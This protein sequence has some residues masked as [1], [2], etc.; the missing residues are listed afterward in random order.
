M[1]AR[2]RQTDRATDRHLC[3]CL[4]IP[5][6]SNTIR[7]V[8]S[9]CKQAAQSR[10][11]PSLSLAEIGGNYSLRCGVEA[12]R[13]EEP[14]YRQGHVGRGKA[15]RQ[16]KIVPR[17]QTGSKC[18]KD[19]GHSSWSCE[20]E[21]GCSTA[22]LSDTFAF[23]RLLNMA[24]DSFS[25]AA[26]PQ[27]AATCLVCDGYLLSH[28]AARADEKGSRRLVPSTPLSASPHTTGARQRDHH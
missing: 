18:V 12:L 26:F 23:T 28:G 1:R 6:Q 27:W 13:E 15:W 14:P 7:T 21:P 2:H 11:R 24:C 19:K 20:P 16:V 17:V 4:C 8:T 5:M 25:C 22:P 9:R 10:P 3:K